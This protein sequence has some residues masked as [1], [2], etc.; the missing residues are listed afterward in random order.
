M[1]MVGYFTAISPEALHD[2]QSDPDKMEE[3]LFPNDGDGE[4]ENTI[5]VDKSWHGIHF[6]LTE[7]AK[8]GSTVLESTILGGE[9]LGED[10][11]Y[12][13]PRILSPS[14]VKLIATALSCISIEQIESVFDPAA[15]DDAGIYPQ[16]W[17]RDGKESLEYMTNY[18]PSLVAFYAE[19][20]SR[21][22]G[23]IL[24]LA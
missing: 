24:W 9:P 22:D 10:L 4:P 19:A 2:I 16:I 6:I 11:G 21:G 23:V 17:V 18:F 12:G 14:E 15:M 1:G 5:D 8:T 13:P 20:A 7:I 3:F